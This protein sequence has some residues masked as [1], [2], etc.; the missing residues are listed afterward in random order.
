MKECPSCGSCWD[1]DQVRCPEDDRALESSLEG[2]R[3]I[4]GKY[5]LERRLGSGGMGSVYRVRHKDLQKIFALKLIRVRHSQNADYLN[6]FRIEARALGKLQHPH[7]VQVSDYGID[8]R[9]G[10][11]PYLVMEYLEGMTLDQCLGGEPLLPMSRVLSIAGSIAGAI[12]YAHDCGVLHR[13]LKPQNIFLAGDP[14]ESR[15]KILDFGLA[16]IA[17]V[18]ARREE[19]GLPAAPP[20]GD[21]R[22]SWAEEADKHSVV[23][24]PGEETLELPDA[25]RMSLTRVGSVMGTPGYMAPEI[26]RGDEAQPASDIYSFGV[27]VYE[28]LVGRKPFEPQGGRPLRPS[29][30][31]STI[32]PELDASFLA[33][34]EANPALRPAKAMAVVQSLKQ[35][36]SLHRYRVWRA[37]EVP[38]RIGLAALVTMALLLLFGI[39]RRAPFVRAAES[40]L[41]D[42]RLSFLAS[43]P[44][45]ERIVLLSIDEATLQ[46]DPTLLADKADEMGERLQKIMDR[47]PLGLGLDFL[48]PER[49]NRSQAFAR[50]VL[51]N[52]DRLILAGYFTEAGAVLGEEL[53]QGLIMAALGSQARVERLLGFVNIVPDEDGRIRRSSLGFEKKDGSRL[54]S[55]P[56][57]A[58]RLITGRDAPSAAGESAFKIDFSID[59]HR[60]QRV[61][62]KDLPRLLDEQPELFRGRFIFVG[63]EYEG[64]QDYHR[65]PRRPG[66]KAG[67]VSGMVLQALALDTLLQGRPIRDV[68]PGFV[69]LL[70]GVAA[71]LVSSAF[72]IRPKTVLPLLVW[73]GITAAYLVSSVVLAVGRRL[74]LPAGLPFFLSILGLIAVLALRRGLTFVAKEG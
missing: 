32:P 37:R 65:I 6:R 9:C 15:V 50:F 31:R 41:A 59:R 70:I 17:D 60:Y 63:G 69:A 8:A 72:F 42:L 14:S 56:A 51:R 46:A 24:N 16:R 18:P 67:D 52:Q 61:S 34:L 33:P 13:D 66:E 48:L 45:D 23:G 4:D 26:G 73:A 2:S 38:R 49:W 74:L 10:G 71:M 57:R 44:P 5:I 3:I 53:F 28:M 68:P 36:F 12:D 21:E 43:R 35:A 11:T 64:S 25:E 39:L 20:A 22:H 30:S 62:W 7:I 29:L 27:L 47:R 40:S 55:M 1:D 19:V 58:F 54:F